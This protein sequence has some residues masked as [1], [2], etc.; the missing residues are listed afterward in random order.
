MGIE[1]ERVP[2]WDVPFQKNPYFTG[3]EDDLARLHNA[4]AKEKNATLTQ[5]QVISGLGGVGKTQLAIEYAYRFRNDYQYTFWVK[6]DT[7]ELIVSDF[8]EIANLV[9]LSIKEEKDQKLIV[10]AVKNWLQ[11]H[12]N[13]L[14]IFD[15]ADNLEDIHTFL[16]QEGQ[17]HVLLTTHIP[18]IGIEAPGI[19]LN[20]MK[21]EESE[22]FLLHRARL[23]DL[24]ASLETASDID[25]SKAQEIASIMGNLPLALAQAGAYIERTQCGL[26]G[27]L[28]RYQ[29]RR[30]ILLKER[31]GL[32]S[33]H[34]EPVATTWSLSFERVEQVN[35][36]AADLLRLCAFLHPD[37]IPEA[38]LISGTTALTP[39]LQSVATDLFTLDDTIVQLR[40]Y[41]LIRRNLDAKTLTVHRL[42]QA[43]LKDSMDE[44]SQNEWAERT[45][46]ALNLV[47]PNGDF[48]TW[49]QC[50]L[51][52]PHVQVCAELIKQWDLVFPE[53]VRLLINAGHYLT[54]R[55]QYFEA[56]ALLQQALMILEKLPSI[57]LATLAENLHHL[58]D[59]YRL[60][61]RYAQ[62]LPLFEQSLAMRQQTLGPDHHNVASTL[63]NMAKLYF[64]Q[65]KYNQAEQLYQQAL[66]IQEKALGPEHPDVISTLRN[67]ALNYGSQGKYGQAE[68]LYRRFYTFHLRS[69]G[70]NNPKTMEA[71][72]YYNYASQQA[73]LRNKASQK[74][75]QKRKHR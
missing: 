75:K 66:T 59:L 17:G 54:E 71:L 40:R 43:V 13:W 32:A 53:T 41:S 55:G 15:N 26:S 12:I 11:T 58:A 68:Q 35:P 74:T 44:A 60:W 38:I 34:P 37:A 56:E 46:R 7:T 16:P 42:V 47:F 31:S 23:L 63:N 33:D 67:M 29:K 21:P 62:A 19:E 48:S 65:A 64:H 73:R 8:A 2:I 45:L 18:F 49:D 20:T 57:E 69:L 1:T 61:G 51:Y 5:L 50:Q 10:G 3:R 25:R 28:E 9:N 6:A 52:L 4:L 24:D 14:L 30:A 70:P 36:A 72:K 39:V 27:Y 22:L